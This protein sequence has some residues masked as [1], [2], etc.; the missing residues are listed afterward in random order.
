MP[1]VPAAAPGGPDQSVHVEG[2]ITV[3]INAER[4]EADAARLLSDEIIQR[5]QERLAT[6]RS[7]QDFRAGTRAPAPA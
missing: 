7:E 1:A 5:I 6:L 4:L 2:G 3:N